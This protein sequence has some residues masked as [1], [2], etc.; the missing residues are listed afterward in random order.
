MVR[1]RQGRFVATPNSV[2]TTGYTQFAAGVTV[3]SDG[4]ASGHVCMIPAVVSI[5]GDVM[6][7]WVNEDGSVTVMG[8]RTATITFGEPFFDL[9]SRSP[10]GMEGRKM[11]DLT[12]AMSPVSSAWSVRHRGRDS[13]H[14][15][16][17]DRSVILR[18]LDSALCLVFGVSKVRRFTNPE[19]PNTKHQTPAAASARW[20]ESLHPPPDQPHEGA[21][22]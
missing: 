6:D 15:H 5:S 19:T 21:F 2:N 7:G 10:S 9:R 11:A 16:D 17:R 12:T 1:R 14:D 18:P 3:H 4:T 13:R 8:L 22:P 20:G